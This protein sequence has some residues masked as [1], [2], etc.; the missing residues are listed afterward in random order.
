MRRAPTAAFSPDSVKRDVSEPTTPCQFP[1]GNSTAGSRARCGKEG[2][3]IR[4]STAQAGT[5]ALVPPQHAALGGHC[6]G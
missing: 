3:E 2:Q 5:A 6:S 1:T 4:Q